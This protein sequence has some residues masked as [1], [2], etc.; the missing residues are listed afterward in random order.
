MVGSTSAFGQ[1]QIQQAIACLPKRQGEALE[2]LEH[3]RLSYEEIAARMGTSHG[4]VA[5]LIAR[6]RINLYDELRGTPLASVAA[7]SAECQRS[8][9][10]IAARED[11]QLESADD[12]GAWLDAHLAACDRCRPAV[13]QMAEAAVAYRAWAAPAPSAPAPAARPAEAGAARPRRRTVVLVATS[14]A[15]VLLGGLAAAFVRD[16]GAPSSADPA[17]EVAAP[18]TGGG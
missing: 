16:G 2:L 12:E 5:Q 7:P 9:P 11:G 14:L 1:E 10:L 13:E 3:D 6:A 15:V 17:T 8:L 4:S 18:G